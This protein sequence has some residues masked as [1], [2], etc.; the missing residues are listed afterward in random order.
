MPYLSHLSLGSGTIQKPGNGSNYQQ[1][2]L[3]E[4]DHGD[5]FGVFATTELGVGTNMVDARTIATWN[6]NDR[7][8]SA[9]WM[10]ARGSMRSPTSGPYADRGG[11]RNARSEDRL[12]RTPIATPHC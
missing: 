3:V 6:R 2:P 11:G 1:T 10:S 4:L 12:G 8:L 9:C 7:S 5:M